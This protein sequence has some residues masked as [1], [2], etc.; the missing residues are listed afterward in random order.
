M[1]RKQLCGGEL[2]C[3]SIHGIALFSMDRDGEKTYRHRCDG[4]GEVT[5]KS[6]IGG[7]CQR[8][9]MGEVKR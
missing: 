4:C 9:A 3:E 7:A 2:Q 6:T 1:A 5:Y 8:G